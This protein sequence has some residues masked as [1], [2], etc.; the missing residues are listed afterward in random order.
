MRAAK[1]FCRLENIKNM[2]YAHIS[3]KNLYLYMDKFR[4]IGSMTKLPAGLPNQNRKRL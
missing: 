3:Y 2:K 1:I 4:D